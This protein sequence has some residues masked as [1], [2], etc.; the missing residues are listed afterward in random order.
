[1][2]DETRAGLARLIGAQA[3][4]IAFVE[5]TKQGEQIVLDGLPALRDGGNVVTDD[6][7]FAGSLHNLVGLRR[8]GV[9]VRIVRSKNWRTD[10][11]ATPWRRPSTTTPRWSR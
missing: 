9:D 5:C 1:M 4:E 11:D 8:T 6:L 2:L 10:V 3:R 7:H